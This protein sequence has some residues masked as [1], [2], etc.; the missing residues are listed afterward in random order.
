VGQAKLIGGDNDKLIQ[1]VTNLLSNAIKF[2]AEGEEIEVRIRERHQ[3]EHLI[4][5]SVTDT[6]IGI[7]EE[8]I[9][10]VFDKFRQ[11]S[12][13]DPSGTGLGLTICKM[14]Q[15]RSWL[16]LWLGQMMLGGP[17]R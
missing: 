15:T 17:T 1:V 2:T 16:F 10:K 8:E 7:R 6:G 11:G 9:D 14:N 5:V 4:Q 3:P 12:N 13:T